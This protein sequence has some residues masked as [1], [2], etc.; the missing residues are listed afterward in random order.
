MFSAQTCCQV[1]RLSWKARKPTKLMSTQR[2]WNSTLQ[3]LSFSFKTAT[4]W[5]S[6]RRRL[7]NGTRPVCQCPPIRAKARENSWTRRPAAAPQGGKWQRRSTP[8]GG[9]AVFQGCFL[10]WERLWVWAG[11]LALLKVS[12]CLHPYIDDVESRR[13][14]SSKLLSQ[15]LSSLL[16]TPPP[17]QPLGEHLHFLRLEVARQLPNV[18]MM[19]SNTF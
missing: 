6:C 4:A 13:M 15:V 7:K 17:C 11:P 14:L 19:V 9:Q 3:S 18:I 2:S 10:L 8:G 12:P 1:K 5:V 16:S